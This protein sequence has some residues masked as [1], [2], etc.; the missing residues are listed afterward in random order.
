MSYELI[1]HTADFGLRVFGA[2]PVELFET[3]GRALFD[4]ITDRAALV[5]DQ[6]QNIEVTGDDWPDLMV[7]WL[8]EL[9]YQ[10]AG[11][12]LLVREVEITTL[13]E[14]RLSARLRADRF[15]PARHPIRNEI[16]AVTYHQIAVEADEAGWEARV[17]FDV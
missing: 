7:N 11:N 16:K 10:W 6:C 14:T 8:R 2:D 4:Q 5:G 3:A 1:D 13:C 12:D 15:D 9:L 17:I